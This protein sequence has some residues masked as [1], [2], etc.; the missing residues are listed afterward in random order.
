[1]KIV[2]ANGG[3]AADYIIKS[4]KN[5]KNKLIIINDN[6]V[7]ADKLAKANRVPVIYGEPYKTEILDVANVYDAD[8]FISLGEN[9]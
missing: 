1:M 2:I 6:R 7:E 3:H 4:F 8:L 9:D 5:R